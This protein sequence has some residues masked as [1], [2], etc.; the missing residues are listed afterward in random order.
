MIRCPRCTYLVDRL[1]AVV[2]SELDEQTVCVDCT[3]AAL[4]QQAIVLKN[5]GKSKLEIEVL[6]AAGGKK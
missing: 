5:G 2:K 1:F 6:E 3:Q 4:L